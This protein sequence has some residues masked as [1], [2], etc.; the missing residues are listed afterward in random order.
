[1]YLIYV[2]MLKVYLKASTNI[3]LRNRKMIA[4]IRNLDQNIYN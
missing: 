4:I 1:M 3:D 2:K